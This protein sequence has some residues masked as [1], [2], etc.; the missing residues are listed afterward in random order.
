[1]VVRACGGPC[2]PVE[3]SV[4]SPLCRGLGAGLSAPDTFVKTAG[5]AQSVGAPRLEP[6]PLGPASLRELVGFVALGMPSALAI[7]T[8]S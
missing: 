6:R 4:P 3:A 5:S 2:C 1:M 7:R 8:P